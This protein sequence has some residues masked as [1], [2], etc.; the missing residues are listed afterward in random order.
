M[1]KILILPLLLLS[2]SLGATKVYVATTGNDGTGNGTAAAPYATIAAGISHASAGDTVYVVAGTYNVSTQITVPVGVSLMGAGATSIITTGAALEP[3][4]YMYSASEGTNGNQ[5]ISHLKVDGDMTAITLIEILGRSNVLVHD[6]E[7]VDA[8]WDG[9]IF[10]G[11]VD[12]LD[13][14]PTTYATG[15]KFYNNTVTNCAI[16]DTGHA[17]NKGHGNVCY[18]GQKDMEIYDNTITQTDRG[19]TTHGYGIKFVNRGFSVGLKIYRNTITVPEYEN[20]GFQFCMELWCQRGG[21]QIYD[22][23]INGEIDIA[24]YDTNDSANYGYAVRI[25]RN[26]IGRP[27]LQTYDSYGIRFELG[28]HDGSYIYQN[29]FRNIS[30]P[31]TFDNTDSDVVPGKEDVYIYYNLFTNIRRAAAG[32]YGYVVTIGNA[33]T[34]ITHDNFQFLNNVVYNEAASTLMAFIGE[35][36]DNQTYTNWV[37]KNNIICGAH[38]HVLFE[39]CTVTGIEIE[40]NIFYGSSHGVT[41]TNCTTS[42]TTNVNNL[43]D[44]PLFKSNETF[45]LRPTSPAIDAGLDVGLTKDYQGHRVP[46]NGTPDIGA[47]EAGNY[48]L[49]YNGKQ[50]Y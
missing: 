41:Y 22:N 34:A 24:G 38:Y 33:G 11:R 28:I 17:W 42:D 46:Q 21:L 44:N 47:C 27:R 50:L 1:K 36:T 5:S 23:V 49:F 20:A 19:G 8:L 14:A 30:R 12:S 13:R 9:V 7:F 40:N 16:Y 15:N 3:I 2:L 26:T 4:I 18:G 39:N 37:I 48:V 45:R 29:H 35:N 31:F 43:T 25:Y 10:R 6:C 32:W